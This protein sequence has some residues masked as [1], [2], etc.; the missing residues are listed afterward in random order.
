VPSGESCRSVADW[1][2][3]S[4]NFGSACALSFSSAFFFFS[5]SMR[6]CSI[7]FCSSALTNFWL[8]VSRGSRLRGWT[9]VSW[10]SSPPSSGTRNRLLSRVK[11]TADSR[12]AQ[13][14]LASLPVVRVIWWRVP[15]TVS[16]MTIS[17]RSMKSTRRRAASHRPATGG[18]V[19]RSS[20]ESLRGAP[21][22]RAT[23]QVDASSSPGRRHSKNSRDE[24]PAQRRPAGG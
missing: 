10:V 15:A 14:G 11:V 5:A 19:R 12:R 6:V 21:P 16:S 1:R 17:P 24:S 4:S 22:S 2:S 18:A 13:R 23:T 3:A 8:S 20:S 9:S 7:S